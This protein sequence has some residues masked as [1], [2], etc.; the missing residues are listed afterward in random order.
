MSA[1]ELVMKT[2][3]K[4]SDEMSMEKILEELAI[5]AAIQRGEEAADAGK[6]ISHDELVAAMA[7][8]DN[9]SERFGPTRYSPCH[10]K[11]WSRHSGELASRY[12][13]EFASRC[14]RPSPELF[15]KEPG[16]SHVAFLPVRDFLEL[17]PR[18]HSIGRR[19]VAQGPQI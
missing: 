5:L 13:I 19:P 10:G 4:M 6:V 12:L 14:R 17:P 16:V 1:K 8:E 2:V 11:S 18:G 7:E 3:R 9:L 15:G